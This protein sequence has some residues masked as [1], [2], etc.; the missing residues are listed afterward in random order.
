LTDETGCRAPVPP[1][2]AFF[3]EAVNLNA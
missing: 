2:L 3:Y 1:L